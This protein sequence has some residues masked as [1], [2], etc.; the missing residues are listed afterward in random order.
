MRRPYL[1]KWVQIGLKALADPTIF[2]T[3][4]DPEIARGVAAAR[5]YIQ[6]MNA[7]REKRRKEARD[8]NRRTEA[9]RR[10]DHQPDRRG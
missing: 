2:P 10:D 7:W 1:T 9:L 8:A 4:V 5:R 6:Q 3:P